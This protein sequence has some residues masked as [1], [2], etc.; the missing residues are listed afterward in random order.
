MEI[1]QASSRESLIK[2][3]PLFAHFSADNLIQLTSL[4]HEVN[5]SEHQV[6]VSENEP[7]DSVFIIVEG[8]VE[9][10][11]QQEVLAVLYPGETIGLNDTGFFSQTGVRTATV[12]ALTSV[13]LLQLSLTDFNQFLNKHPSLIPNVQSTSRILL[14]QNFL[15]HIEPFSKINDKTLQQVAIAIEEIDFPAETFIFHQ[16]DDADCCY[17]LCSGNV[18]VIITKVDNT[19]Q[20]LEKLGPGSLFGELALLTKN[21]RNASVKTITACKV[22]RLDEKHFHQLLEEGGDNS[23]AIFDI[24]MD[25]YRPEQI[26]NI[27]IHSRSNSENKNI[28]I[29]KNAAEGMYFQLS[30]EALFV[31]NRL[32]GEH[33]IQ[34]IAVEFFYKFKKIGIDAIANLV[35]RLMKTGFVKKPQLAFYVKSSQAPIWQRFLFSIIRLLQY[36]Y[37]F[38]NV[39]PWLTKLYNNIGYLFFTKAAHL[40]M[41][42]L[43]IGGALTFAG[44]FHQAELTLKAT[45]HAWLLLVL[46]G[47]ANILT[48][49]LHEL[50]H[51]LTT[52]F[53]GFQVH[54]MGVGWFWLG[55]MA[56]TDTSDMWLSTRGPRM[57]VNFA[58]IYLSAALSG[59]LAIIAWFLPYP[60]VAVFLWLVALDGYLLAIY[61][62]NPL[63]ELDGYYVMMD[64]FDKPNL[65]KLATKW[66]VEDAKK[67][68]FSKKLMRQHFPEIMYWVATI[69]FILF[70]SFLAYLTQTYIIHSVLPEKIGPVHPHYFRWV[71]SLIVIILS[72]SS[73]YHEIKEVRKRHF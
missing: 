61:N 29:L 37:D 59:L 12:T 23:E 13:R 25:R 42:F 15:K 38:K 58:G 32:D 48:V 16:G 21:K 34:Q 24:I 54:R 9:V 43:V 51:A 68:F 52:K 62:L 60:I 50:A 8:N 1:I 5:Y 73:I 4:F 27:K 56:F 39:D 26:Y 22:L 41:I 65:R 11:A 33:T 66:L 46:M 45:P 70:V 57:A 72:F 67:T 36:K 20:V 40:L 53:Y 71:L 7:I 3:L 69:L 30:E 28:Y 6:I 10:A 14:R 2:N 64:A 47:P 63:F 19:N 17:L 35:V 55:P 18:N 49:P 31:W 44:F